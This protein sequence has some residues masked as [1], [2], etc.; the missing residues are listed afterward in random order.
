MALQW[1]I[2]RDTAAQWTAENPYLAEGEWGAETDEIG[3]ENLKIKIGDGINRWND[4]DYIFNISKK[5]KVERFLATN[6][7][8]S[9][10]VSASAIV[11]DGLSEVQVNG[12]NWNSRTGI[13]SFT[14]GNISIDFVTGA[15]TFHIPLSTDDQVIIKYN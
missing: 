12:Q 1:Q 3:T 2:R 15:I 5:K 8:V 9:F 4:L 6:G 13:T 10:S 11:D 7:Q 14:G